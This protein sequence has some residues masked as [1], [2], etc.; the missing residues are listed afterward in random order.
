MRARGDAHQRAQDA[1]VFLVPNTSGL[2]AAYPGFRDKLVG[3]R[4][5]ARYAAP[6]AD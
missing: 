1:R 4:R 3:Y 6:K 5:L 2:N